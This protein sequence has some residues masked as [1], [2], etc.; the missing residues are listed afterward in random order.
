MA[1]ARADVSD[2]MADSIFVYGDDT[3]T[4]AVTES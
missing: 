1:T 4:H 3:G 2:V